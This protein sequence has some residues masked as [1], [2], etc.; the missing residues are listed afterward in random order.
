MP[1]PHIQQQPGPAEEAV[2]GVDT[3]KDR[4]VAV[5][6]SMTG[7]VLDDAAF[8]T[9]TDGYRQLVAWARAHGAWCRAGVE[10]T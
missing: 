6:L 10:G 4:H 5:A 1:D 7:R 8:V 2:I 9:T 3:H